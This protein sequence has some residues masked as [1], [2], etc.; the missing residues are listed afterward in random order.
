MGANGSLQSPD[1]PSSYIFSDHGPLKVA[2]CQDWPARALQC[3]SRHR[4]CRR[5]LKEHGVV[6]CLVC[7]AHLAPRPPE[8]LVGQL[9]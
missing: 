4:V 6:C 3:R 5:I 1:R 2:K 7:T 8:T 9:S